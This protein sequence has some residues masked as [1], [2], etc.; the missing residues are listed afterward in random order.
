MGVAIQFESHRVELAVVH[1]ME[2]DPDVLE[3]Y[4]QPPS[5]RLE[6]Q[7]R[8]ERRLAVLHT[9]DYFAIRRESAGWEECKTEQELNQL[10][11]KSPHRYCRQ[12]EQWCCPPGQR[13]AEGY[14]LY[15]RVRSSRE[16][17]WVYQRNLL[18]LEDYFRIDPPTLENQTCQAVLALVAPAGTTLADLLH[19]AQGAQTHDDIYQL[20]ACGDVYVDLHAAPLAEPHRV[21]VFP[22]R[23][24]ALDPASGVTTGP[25]QP[26]VGSGLL[27]VAVGTEVVW[28]GRVWTIVNVGETMIEFIGEGHAFTGVPHGIFEEE[29]SSFRS[30]TLGAKG[31]RGRGVKGTKHHLEPSIPLP[32][33]Q[34]EKS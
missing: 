10:A 18:F 31:Q 19:K 21:Q 7:D 8:N 14:G 32:L 12:G 5:F 3:Y 33:E 4:D 20:I 2:R 15:Y 24:S 9:P 13:Y 11:E 26:I 6:Y 1:E 30:Q 28:D 25:H 27:P 34:I 17:N 22:R 23:E 29:L 16:T